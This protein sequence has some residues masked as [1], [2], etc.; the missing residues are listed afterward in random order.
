MKVI[1]NPYQ[2]ERI[3]TTYVKQMDKRELDALSCYRWVVHFVFNSN[4]IETDW[5]Y[6]AYNND[7]GIEV[8]SHIVIEDH[9]KFLSWLKNQDKLCFMVPEDL[10]MQLEKVG[11]TKIPIPFYVRF[12]DTTMKKYFYTNNIMLLPLL[13][14]IVLEKL[15]D[16]SSEEQKRTDYTSGNVPEESLV[17]LFY[18]WKDAF[19]S[20]DRSKRVKEKHILNWIEE[21]P[22]EDL[23]STEF[24]EL[25]L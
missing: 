21:D 3:W 14:G 20:L 25:L 23:Y 8:P 24:E 1:K 11:Y 6:I 17:H 15:F 2:L 22:V 7:M 5:G 12:R 9:K 16:F 18:K 19:Y 10:G 4:L 13:I